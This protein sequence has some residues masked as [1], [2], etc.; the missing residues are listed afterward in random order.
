[1]SNLKGLGLQGLSYFVT[2]GSRGIGKSIV[3]LLAASGA[4]VAFSYA[5]SEA[6]AQELIK[7]LPGEGHFAVQLKLEDP[8]SIETAVDHVSKELGAIEGIVN[9]AGL[10]RD[11]LLMR[12]KL[13]DWDDVIN[14]NLRGTFL[15]TQGFLRGFIKARRG[16]I[17]NVTSVIGRIGNA[18]QA[19]YAA[20]KAGIIGFT[21]S[22]AKE[23]GTRGIRVN[24]VAPGFIKTDMTKDLNPEVQA[25]I[26]AQIPLGYFAEV[27]DVAH[28]VKFLLQPE[29]RYITG[30]TL[31][32]NGGMYMS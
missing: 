30:Q 23:V 25:T 14:A 20:S 7:T 12:M 24:C 9:N 1:V 8:Q 2:G 31:D 6:S 32:V 11:G 26:L 16:S 3:Q 15:V 13:Q 28:A 19:N 22:M 18:G 29:S 21:K 27:E 4:R 17:V 5:Q 10:T